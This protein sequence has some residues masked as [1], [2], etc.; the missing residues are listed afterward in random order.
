MKR[1][2]PQSTTPAAAPTVFTRETFPAKY[3]LPVVVAPPEM[4][5][6]PTCVPLPI[7]ELAL[8]AMPSVV[9]GARKAPPKISHARPNPA[10]VEGHEARQS[11]ER[12]RVVAESAVVEAKGKTLAVVEVAVKKGAVIAPLD[13]TPLTAS[14]PAV[15][16]PVSER[17]PAMLPPESGR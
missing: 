8:T 16:V 1:L 12:Q 14:A 7:V 9:V 5:R 17:S 2:P 15:S 4:V 10:A 3:A 6:P 11:L 13:E